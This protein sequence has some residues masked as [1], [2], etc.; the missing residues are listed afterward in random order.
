MSGDPVLTLVVPV[1]EEEENIIPFLREVAERISVPHRVLII[2]DDEHDSTLNQAARANDT[3][4]NMS[5]VKNIYGRGVINAFKTGFALADTE[6]IVPIMAD[7]SDTPET[8]SAMYRKIQEGYD[9]VV[10]S[11]YVRGGAKIGGPALKAILSRLAN[12]SLHFLAGIP[13]HDLTNAFVIYRKEILN[14]ITIQSKGGFEITMELIAK[15]FVLGCKITEVPTVNRDRQ[16][17]TSKFQLIR[18]IFQYV[19]WYFFIL[20][21]ALARRLASAV[22][23][24]KGTGNRVVS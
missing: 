11:R 24:Q 23:V 20:V 17:G 19:R 14:G 12:L 13:T 16:A 18:W 2:Y 9:L 21:A 8:V 1:Y 10:A 5:F 4:P 7:L 15:A 3:H 6:Y 22:S